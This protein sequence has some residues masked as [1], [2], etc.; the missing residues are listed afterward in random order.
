MATKKV[1]NKQP[2]KKNKRGPYKKQVK[3]GYSIRFDKEGEPVYEEGVN[4]IAIV[5]SDT[6]P[7]TVYIAFSNKS[8]QVF[9][10][11]KYVYYVPDYNKL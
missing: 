9:A 10:G 6:K 7:L 2:V 8:A 1:A 5:L 11:Y 3:P 4:C